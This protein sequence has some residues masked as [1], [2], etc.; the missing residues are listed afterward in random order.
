[1]DQRLEIRAEQHPGGWLLALTGVI[2]ET[3]KRSQLFDG[4]QGVLVL[5]LDNVRR[6]TSYGVREWVLAMSEVQGHCFFIRCRPAVVSQ[7]NMVGNFG[8]HGQL[9][10][11]YAPYACPRCGMDIEVLVDRRQGV[12]ALAPATVVCPECRT[13][14]EFDDIPE[15][16]FSYAMAAPSPLLPPTAEAIID[17]SPK[18]PVGRLRVEKE[19][20]GEVTVLWLHGPLD[21]STHLKRVADGLQGTAVVV[22]SGVNAVTDDGL[23][24]FQ[25]L[26]RSPDAR[27]HVARVPLCLWAA[28][29]RAPEVLGR[30]TVLSVRVPFACWTC[31]RR[32]DVDA[33]VVRL[34]EIAA[35]EDPPMCTIC[36]A[37]LGHPGVDKIQGLLGLPFVETPAHVAGC[38]LKSPSDGLAESASTASRVITSPGAPPMTPISTRVTELQTV[39]DRLH[40]YEIL[41]RLAVGGMATVYLGRMHGA[42]G[43]ERRVAI[44]LMHPHIATNASFVAMFLDEA[45]LAARIHHPNVVATLDIDQKDTLLFIVMEYIEG[46]TVQQVTARYHQQGLAVPTSHALRII[47]DALAGLHAAHELRDSDGTPL[48][49]VHRDV[50]PPNMIVG[51]DGLTRVT[52]FGIA[53]ASSRVG[54]ETKT[55]EIKGKIRYMSPEQL[56]SAPI[57]CR[58]DVYAMGVVLWEMLSWRSAIRGDTEGA[59]LIAALQGITQSPHEINRAAK[60]EISAACMRALTQDPEWRIATA[61]AFADDLERA[62]H[63]ARVPIASTRDVGTMIKQLMAMETKSA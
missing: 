7:F 56:R 52:D 28:L 29:R 34:G 41:R 53:R 16:F 5:D 61:A 17:R 59:T 48:R 10:S 38:N 31:G 40:R 45:R 6:I 58:S 62:A 30:A 3:F 60:P 32:L 13:P 55:G 18:T 39:P 47:I 4:R 20:Q 54:L 42:G 24:R 14:A 26:A 37:P 25:A 51:V 43:F 8:G 27:I 9:V 21:H 49:L 33:D 35:G 2:D 57:D 36:D 50:S 22:L 44:K 46:L 19:V 1:M 63:E 12:G 11:M 15:T 23:A